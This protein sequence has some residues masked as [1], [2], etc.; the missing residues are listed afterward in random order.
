MKFNLRLLIFLLIFVESLLLSAQTH[1]A[2]IRKAIEAGSAMPLPS[3]YDSF[4]R[5]SFSSSA[6]AVSLIPALG[7]FQE[8]VSRL[9]LPG[10]L[11]IGDVPG[12]ELVISSNWNFSGDIY[13]LGDGKLRF[14]GATAM[15]YGNI[16]ALGNALVEIDHSE[17]SFPQAYFYQRTWALNEN[18]VMYLR[19]SKV[20][21]GGMVHNMIV[22]GNA[23]FVARNAEN[24][25]F[26]TSSVSDQATVDIDSIDVA[27][28]FV[29]AGN[30]QLHFAHVSNLLLWH[31]FP[32]GAV[33]NHTFPQ[34][35]TLQHYDFS[36]ATPGISG[37]SY[38]IGVDTSTQVMWGLMPEEE[39]S[40]SI[41]D[42]EIR[43][44]GLWFRGNDT[45]QVSGLVNNS[46]Y[47]NYT[48][49][50]PDRYLHFQNCSL[51]TWSLYLFDTTVVSLS[52]SIVGEVGTM[53]RSRFNG[54]NYWVDGSG[55]YIFANDTTTLVSNY[56]THTCNVRSDDYAIF[57]VGQSSQSVGKCAALGGSLMMIL[58]SDINGDPLLYDSASVW[59][60]YIDD[61]ED[62]YTDAS[63]LIGGSAW[64]DK[65][66]NSFWPG[67]SGYILEYQ[68][69]NAASW[70]GLDTI[71]SEKRREMLGVWNT[72]GLAAGTY[73][74][75]MRMFD[76]NQD[77]VQVYRQVVLLP[78]FLVA[79]EIEQEH[80]SVYPNPVKRGNPVA[81][82]G[83]IPKTAGLTLVSA[84]GQ[85]ILSRE[86]TN[87]LLIPPDLNPGFYYL[88]IRE[89]EKKQVVKIVVCE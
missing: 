23:R 82:Q 1:H 20:T 75:R 13:I 83:C 42:S 5:G 80:Y 11:V 74:L 26:T 84:E 88:L 81:I 12:E 58:Q 18:A 50:L 35:D 8:Q 41:S 28:E 16:Y 66:L 79:G 31:H 34:G 10:D 69:A 57:I 37:I 43:T 15:I 2:R 65:G 52:G 60:A 59:M 29:I 7:Y 62:A 63:V 33:I 30:A 70:Q 47:N 78:G 4:T 49:S 32:K 19:N 21:F 87:S 3:G 55:G 48:A 51:Q 6:P 44:I 24:P 64:I 36:P 17:L 39:T 56:A 68:A 85:R 22:A 53:G 77:T 71:Y 89:N 67:F 86:N 61:P 25:D 76:D 72:E 46:V 38:T 9:P 73:V 40:V 54:Q 27:G 14:T 45:T